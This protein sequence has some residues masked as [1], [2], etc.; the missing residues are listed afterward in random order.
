MKKWIVMYDAG[1][2]GTEC[3]KSCEAKTQVEAE[4]MFYD[5]VYAW[6]DL[7]NPC[8]DLE[9]MDEFDENY[10]EACDEA[11]RRTEV[12]AYAVEYNPNEHDAYRCGK[13][14]WAWE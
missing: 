5:S 11:D 1:M 13:S 7:F 4:E 2:P 10:E 8:H 3:Y 14:K 12:F 9:D 6:F